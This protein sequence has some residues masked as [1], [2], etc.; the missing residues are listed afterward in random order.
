MMRYAIMVTY[1]TVCVIIIEQEGSLLFLDN[2]VLGDLWFCSGQSMQSIFNA[3]LEVA[4]S[5][6]YNNI[7]LYLLLGS[8]INRGGR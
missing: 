6:A 4:N 3:T 5:A 8:I 7:R 1:V 2:V